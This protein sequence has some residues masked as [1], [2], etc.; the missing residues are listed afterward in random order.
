MRDVE[1][2]LANFLLNTCWQSL[3][4]G[5][6]GLLVLKLMQRRAATERA[7]TALCC[8]IVLTVL[9]AVNG[10]R[11]KYVSDRP[12]STV[13]SADPLTITVP[14]QALIQ[15][16]PISTTPVSLPQVELKGIGKKYISA[17]IWPLTMLWSFGTLLLLSRL[18]YGMIFLRG[19][20]FG[21]QPVSDPK[22]DAALARVAE[23]LPL[24]R[25]PAVFT[26]PA[27]TSPLTVGIFRP[28]MIMPEKLLEKLSENEICSIVLHEFSHVWHRDHLT[29][30]FKRLAIAVNWWNPTIYFI[31]TAH[32]DAAEEL[33]DNCALLQ[34]KPEDYSECLLQLA[35]K[36]GLISR[37]PATI[38]MAARPGGLRQRIIKLL[39]KD[40]KIEMKTSPLKKFAALTT[41]AA[42][43]LISGCI[44]GVF[45]QKQAVPPPTSSKTMTYWDKFRLWEILRKGGNEYIARDEAKNRRLLEEL[46]RGLWLVTFKPVNGFNPRNASEFLN[47]IHACSNTRSG[48]NRVGG[49]SFFRTTIA[50]KILIGSFLSE[51]PEVLKTN[52]NKSSTIQFISSEAVT[53]ELF[54]KYVD[55]PQESLPTNSET[56]DSPSKVAPLTPAQLAQRPIVVDTF[57]RHGQIVDATTV[58][59]LRVTFS[60]DMNNEICQSFSADYIN[61]FPEGQNRPRWL[62]KRTCAMSVNLIP[63][64]TY[65]VNFNARFAPFTDTLGRAAIPSKLIFQTAGKN[66]ETP[67]TEKPKVTS[68]SPYNGETVDATAVK[69]IRVTFSEDMNTDGHMSIIPEGQAPFNYILRNQVHWLTPRICVV[70]VK[71]ESGRQY[72]VWFN[73]GKSFRDFINKNGNSSIPYHLTF[74]TAGTAANDADTTVIETFPRQGETVDATAVKELRVTFS[75]DMNTSGCWAFCS[76]GEN[77]FPGSNGKIFW[78][79]KRTCV[80]PIKLIPGR[81]YSVTFNAGRFVG[82]YD[83]RKRPSVSY[84][85]LFQTTGKS[86]ET[87]NSEKPRVVNTFPHHG[88]LVEAA[89]VNE[90]RVTFSEDMNTDGHWSFYPQ[91]RTAAA[92]AQSDRKIHWLNSRTCVIPV[93]L[94]PGEDYYIWFNQGASY[95][96]FINIKGNSSIPYLLNFSAK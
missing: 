19:F 7:L 13:T 87:S 42:A 75:N 59:E 89:A 60:N 69:E 10:I 70:P 95:R 29:G 58:K 86:A 2:L 54:V 52:F 5:L 30:I 4:V 15:P 18:L 63:G 94:K 3:A 34:L 16:V 79:N 21:L 83:S 88:E 65:A 68:I 24:R 57:P 64:R 6:I 11:Q 35:E 66:A 62:D 84:K 1:T 37:L 56:A 96:G 82:F 49:A 45:V 76:D 27:A 50:G 74:K 90:V 22:V 61:F 20:R 17:A 44:G 91:G 71:L 55:S 33:S 36:T 46:S 25:L 72:S 85:L 28:V 77:F 41:A 48:T 26:S 23:I 93:R 9:P 67:D 81:T 51:T 14:Q 92:F 73:A 12:R 32:A 47:E 39:A 43:I 8:M 38:G 53:P 78:Q 80:M 40:R 31:S